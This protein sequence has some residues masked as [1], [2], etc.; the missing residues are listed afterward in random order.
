MTFRVS[1][2]S[3]NIIE[4]EYFGVT[5]YADRGQA[6]D[7]LAAVNVLPAP[8]R[9]LV[10]FL[11]A[12]VSD[13]DDPGR[14]DFIAKAITHPVLDNTKVA[15]VGLS[16]TE[17]HPAETAGVVRLIKVRAFKGRDEAVRWLLGE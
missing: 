10:N 16:R 13:R 14:L 12:N 1:V 5:T 8:K 15:L 9:V 2:T 4:V 7:A 6:L 3:E 11:G 17:A